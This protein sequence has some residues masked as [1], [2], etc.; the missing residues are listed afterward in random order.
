[1]NPIVA[2]QGKKLRIEWKHVREEY[3]GDEPLGIYTT[4]GGKI[5]D[6]KTFKAYT[7]CALKDENGLNVFEGR[8]F[9]KKGDEFVREEGRK[10][11]LT[12]A[13]KDMP[14]EDRGK[15]WYAYF[16]RL[17]AMTDA[18]LEKMLSTKSRR[19]RR[20]AELDAKNVRS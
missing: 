8:A 5:P 16:A 3:D 6:G 7:A 13:I 2:H 1:M 4:M 18:M 20:K 17:D 14:R 19:K 10:R 12:R 15:F 9:C 11:S